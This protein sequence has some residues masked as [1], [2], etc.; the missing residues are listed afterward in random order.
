VSAL[1]TLDVL[2]NAAGAIHM[3]RK[4]TVDGS[5]MTLAVNHLAPFL[6]TKRAREARPSAAALDAS[7]ARL[8][9]VSARMVGLPSRTTA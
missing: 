9:D 4:L 5:E 6:L 8:R 3:T 1:P 7:Q 2:V